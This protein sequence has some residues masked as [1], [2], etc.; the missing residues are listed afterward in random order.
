MCVCVRVRVRVRVCVCVCVSKFNAIAGNTS[1]IKIFVIICIRLVVYH[2]YV[3]FLLSF[4]S[5]TI[6]TIPGIIFSKLALFYSIK[7]LT[8]LF[9][10]K[11][12]NVS[13]LF[14]SLKVK[15]LYNLRAHL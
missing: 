8:I 12:F 11:T 6:M 13:S 3:F 5:V 1:L 9:T 14:V 2:T 10:K 4:Y 15:I 7:Q